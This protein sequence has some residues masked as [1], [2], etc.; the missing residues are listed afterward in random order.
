MTP[1]TD[2]KESIAPG[3][4][5]QFERL[6]SQVHALQRAHAA[7]RGETFRGLH[8]KGQ[9][10]V[11]ASLAMLADVPD[12]ARVGIF[13][14][15]ATY[16][17][18]VRFSN[19]QG[20]RRHDAK[21]DVRGAA[22]KILGVPGKK[23]V[24]GLE[25]ATTQDLLF[26]RTASQPFKNAEEFVWLLG[27][28]DKPALLLPRMIWRFGPVRAL[29]VLRRLV[30][31]LSLPVTSV[32][33]AHYFSALPTR[34]GAYAAKWAL[35]PRA[36]AAPGAPRVRDRDGVHA[37]LAARLRREPVVY[38]LRAQFYRDEAHTPIEDAS[39]EWDAPF[40]DLARLTLPVQDLDAPRGQRLAA[41]VEKLSF[42]PWH[43][44]ED[45]RPLGNMMRARNAAYRLS[46]Q[47]RGAAGEPDGSERFE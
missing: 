41:F 47:E 2:W 42:D 8:A 33:T 3:E 1:A 14:A 34:F 4:A 6:A 46:T 27:V 9:A 24:P 31:G 12:F 36:A 16:R 45:F 5:E 26:I 15:P 44:P 21:P 17:A 10:G 30:R 35:A 13:A 32:A 40:V 38:D 7:R 19:G 28:A 22:L 11:E 25:G 37:E 18:Y 29:S 23:L 43:A 39:R 20:T